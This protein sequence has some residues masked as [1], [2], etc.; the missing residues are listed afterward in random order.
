MPILAATAYVMTNLNLFPGGGSA[1]GLPPM[2]TAIA[3]AASFGLGLLANFG[4][5]NFAPTLV[6]LTLI[7]TGTVG[8]VRPTASVVRA[9][10]QTFIATIVA[11]KNIDASWPVISPGL[12]QGYT[13]AQWRTAHD[14][15]VVPYPGVD[16]K[17]INYFLDY[18][19]NKQILIEVGLSGKPGVSTRPT[20]FQL[21]L[22]PQHGKWLVDYWMP[23]WT[24][25]IPQN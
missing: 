5:G 15:P 25:P 4:V 17:R 19:S 21:G 24:P 22:V 1:T 6:L 7:A 14:L 23:R 2:Q 12:R 10:I 18:A 20:T 3:I 9:E 16:T 13:R 8:L 11:R